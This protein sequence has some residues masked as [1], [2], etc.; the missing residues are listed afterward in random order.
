MTQ[1]FLFYQFFFFPPLGFLSNF[2]F[3]YLRNYNTSKHAS[4]KDTNSSVLRTNIKPKRS[5]G[6]LRIH[7]DAKTNIIY[8]TRV[9]TRW[10]YGTKVNLYLLYSISLFD[11]K[12][13]FPDVSLNSIL[14]SNFQCFL[15]SKQNDF[16]KYHKI[17]D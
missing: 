9:V 12:H 14:D 5:D 2:L 17:F 16:Y 3:D 4:R 8:V 15:L 6:S 11:F 10:S 13:I 7:W 1:K